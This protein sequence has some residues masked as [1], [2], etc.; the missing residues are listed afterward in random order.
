M[1]RGV[2]GRSDARGHEGWRG[3]AVMGS[4]ECG[5]LPVNVRLG[6]VAKAVLT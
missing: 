3:G 1:G 5:E 2:S 4:V 6:G